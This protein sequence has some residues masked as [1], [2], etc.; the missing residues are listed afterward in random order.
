MNVNSVFGVDTDRNIEL[1][2]Y[3]Y[4]RPNLRDDSLEYELYMGQNV[5]RAIFDEMR[6]CPEI[7]ELFLS[8]PE[9][10]LNIIEQ[11]LLFP[12][13]GQYCP[14]LK[15]VTIK[16]HS[17]YIIQCTPNSCC[18]IV[19]GDNDGCQEIDAN[20]KTDLTNKMYS[21]MIGNVFNAKGLN[22]VFHK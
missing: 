6:E 16:T 4:R 15:K 22:V 20:G 9:N 17:V 2:V 19:Q 18:L 21:S 13:L 10:R 14:N 7:T 11:R 1:E 8:F 5:L 3:V 12:R